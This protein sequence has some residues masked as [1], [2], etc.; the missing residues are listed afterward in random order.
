VSRDKTW[1][2]YEDEV[3]DTYERRNVTPWTPNPDGQTTETGTV[4]K[5]DHDNPGPA[6]T[7]FIGPPT[8]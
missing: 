6:A 4:W 7:R 1:G 5:M 3:F 8:P 2:G